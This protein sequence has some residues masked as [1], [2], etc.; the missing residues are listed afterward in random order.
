MFGDQRFGLEW[1]MLARWLIGLVFIVLVGWVAA[2]A[3]SGGALRDDSLE[4]VL[5]RRY[6]RG[7]IDREEYDQRLRDIRR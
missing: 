1:T 2:R 5:K 3:R 7:E 4:A 6:A